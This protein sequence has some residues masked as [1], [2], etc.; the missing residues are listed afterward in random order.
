MTKLIPAWVSTKTEGAALGLMR[1]NA[2]RGSAIHLADRA[3]WEFLKRTNNPPGVKRDEW[4]TVR[5]LMYSFDR[6]LERG[7][8][9]KRAAQHAVEFAHKRILASSA[10]HEPATCTARD[11]TT[12]QKR[13]QVSFPSL[14]S[15]AS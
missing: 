2:I 3:I 12:V 10:L 15:T 13:L 14:H 4:L 1:N 6:S 11:A 7:N 9:S 8:I 5:G